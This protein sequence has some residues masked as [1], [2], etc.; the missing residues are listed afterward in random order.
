MKNLFKKIVQYILFIEARLVIM[1]YKPTIIAITG[2]TNK[3]T[4]KDEL[5]EQFRASRIFVRAN[6]KSYNTEIGLPLAILYLPSGESSFFKWFIILLQGLW[7]VIGSRSFP[8]ICILEFGVDKPGDMSYLL[9]L[10][11]APLITIV[12]DVTSQ[13]ISEF[14][15]LDKISNEYGL[16]VSKTN[17][18][19]LVVLNDDDQRLQQIKP[20]SRANVITVGTNASALVRIFNIEQTANGQT[21]QVEY[22]KNIWELSTKFFGYHNIQARSI[23]I[24]LYNWYEKHN[25]SIS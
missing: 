14:G 10:V 17:P 22:Q 19:G 11:P 4:V 12:T 5:L 6:P 25:K 13:Y 18:N 1:R 21:W 3:T 24:I 9:R 7:I 16:L 23:A 8:A 15:S 2:S 20:R